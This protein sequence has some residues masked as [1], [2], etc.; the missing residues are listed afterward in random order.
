[1]KL[2]IVV[3]YGIY[4]QG[5]FGVF[6]T[7]G[8]AIE[9]ANTAFEAE[10]DNYHSFHVESITLNSAKMDEGSIFEIKGDYE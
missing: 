8:S 10:K 6:D 9:A 7:Q 4:M 5:I 1:M 3:R 2:Y